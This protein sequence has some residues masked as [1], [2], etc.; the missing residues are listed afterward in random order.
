MGSEWCEKAMGSCTAQF[1]M[2]LFCAD[3][4]IMPLYWLSVWQW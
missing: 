4:S 1:K 3:L 2:L